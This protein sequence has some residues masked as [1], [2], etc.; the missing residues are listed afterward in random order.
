MSYEG[1]AV[2]CSVVVHRRQS[3]LRDGNFD[4]FST[5][6]VWKADVCLLPA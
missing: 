6:S 4:L 1:D 5:K 2:S 3:H